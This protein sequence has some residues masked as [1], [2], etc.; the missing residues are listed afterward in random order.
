MTDAIKNSVG[1]PSSSSLPT[2]EEEKKV[3][4]VEEETS[5]ND[6]QPSSMLI[7]ILHHK[8]RDPSIVPTFERQYAHSHLLGRLV[9]PRWMLKSAAS[10]EDDDKANESDKTN[11]KN[12]H[13]TTKATD[14]QNDGITE[15]DDATSKCTDDNSNLLN[16]KQS[17][18]KEKK[19]HTTTYNTI[20]KRNYI[21]LRMEQ[22]T[23]FANNQHLQCQQML[24]KLYTLQPQTSTS[25]ANN[26]RDNGDKQWMKQADTIQ[27][28]LNE[29]LAACPNHEGLLNAEK[30]YKEWIQQRIHRLS[31]ATGGGEEDIEGGVVARTSTGTTSSKTSNNNRSSNAHLPN[32]FPSSTTKPKKGAENRAHMAMRDAILERSFLLGDDTADND[33][34]KKKVDNDNMYPLLSVNDDQLLGSVEENTQKDTATKSSRSGSDMDEDSRSSHGRRKKRSKHKHKRHKRSKSRRS[35]HDRRSRRRKTSSRRRTPSESRSVSRSRSLSSDSSSSSSYYQ[36]RK[37]RR[38]EKKRRKKKRESHR[39]SRGTRYSSEEDD[40]GDRLQPREVA[41]DS[42]K[43]DAT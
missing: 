25:T 38:K 17:Y 32:P 3:Q 28:L 37:H 20:P 40:D 23:L 1:A 7:N 31:D 42:N 4:E 2:Q 27:S 12:T 21:D 9:R 5:T 22:N 11:E 39:E 18:K 30:Q 35:S 10:N 8:L 15:E 6:V 19:N 24:S 16:T 36:R 43:E 14:G 41:L 34:G 33:D 13:D 26:D 29:G